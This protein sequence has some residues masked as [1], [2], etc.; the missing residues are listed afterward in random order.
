V[1]F[2]E[3]LAEFEG[4]LRKLG[5]EW[6]KFFAGVEK[7]PPHDLKTKTDILVRRY[8]HAEIKNATERFRYQN[9]VAK[10]NTMNELWAKK[11]RAREE[12]KVFGL[13]GLKADILPPPP[14]PAPEAPA[15][16]ARVA[17]SG[18]QNEVRVRN[19]ERDS[20]AVQTL[21]NR[22]LAAREQ[23]GE[24]TPVRFENFQKL[25]SQ[26]ASRILTEKG[27]QAVDFRLETKDG[28]VSLK[29]KIV[30]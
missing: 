28:K 29:A 5:V 24:T 14:P 18:E 22:F 21:Y 2:E 6:D 15:P 30:K 17:R 27:G 4:A 19:A 12:G 25:I 9:L 1:G 16:R 20:V 3:D 11:L 26:Q 13:H 10:Y 7:K 8:A 23:A